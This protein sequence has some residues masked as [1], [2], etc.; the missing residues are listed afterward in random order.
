MLT[1]LVTSTK[2]RKSSSCSDGLLL[3]WLRLFLAFL[4]Y[5]F[6]N[7]SELLFESVDEI[8]RTVLEEDNKTEGEK[9]EESEP[10]KAAKD[11]HDGRESNAHIG[12]GQRR[13]AIALTFCT[14]NDL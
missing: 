7:T 9:Y 8:M 13:F 3:L 10:K 2:N 5:E 6:F 11:C 12:R 4:D 14:I 1:V